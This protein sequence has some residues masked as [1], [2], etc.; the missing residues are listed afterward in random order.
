M[1]YPKYSYK[2]RKPYGR[3]ALMFIAMNFV[4][5]FLLPWYTYVHGSLLFV[6]MSIYI[7]RKYRGFKAFSGIIL[8]VLIMLLIFDFVDLKFTWSLDFVFPSFLIFMDVLLLLKVLLAKK[9]W[10]KHYDIHIYIILLNILMIAL[11][12]FGVIESNVMVIVTYSI[13]AVTVIITRIRVGKNYHKDID[14]FT[15]L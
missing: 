3:W 4:L 14:K 5:S 2:K 11:L 6:I 10:T 9:S 7:I 13:I 1:D 15:H 8:S 12:F